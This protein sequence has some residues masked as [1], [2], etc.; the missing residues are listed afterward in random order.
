MLY[1]IILPIIEIFVGAYI[2]RNTGNSS[3]VALYQLCM[4]IG[5]VVTAILNGSLLKRFK[6]EIIYGFG[7]ILSA[8]ILITMMFLKNIDIF[9]L[10]IAGFILGASTGFFWTNRY[11]LTLNAT[12]DDNRNY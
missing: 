2:M 9:T 7:I 10:G 4:Y 8:I 12:N 11:L 6:A 5:I 1:A 3:F